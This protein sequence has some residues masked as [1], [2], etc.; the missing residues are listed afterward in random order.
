[1]K[2]IIFLF[3]LMDLMAYSACSQ[4]I[5]Q[6]RGPDRNG[7]YPETGLMKSW[8][9]TGPALLWHYDELGDGHSSAAVT[10]DRIYTCGEVNGIGYL[11]SF[12]LNGKLLWK[13]PYG[14]EWTESW[15]GVRST[16]LVC[17]G[18]IYMMSGFGKLIC[19]K[20]ESGDFIW[21]IDILKDFKAPNIKW[22]VTENLLIDGNKLFCTP[23]GP[24]ASVVALDRKTGKLLWKCAA[25]G[26]SSAYCSPA[27]FTHNKRRILATHTA[28]SIIGIDTETG[29]FL[30]SVDQP[31]TYSVHANTPEYIDGSIYCVSGYGKGGVLLKLSGDGS[32]VTETWRSPS[33]SNRMGG[34]V[35]LNGKIYGSDDAGKAWY[36][37]DWKTGTDMF[38]EKVT[39]KGN[40][41][42]ADGMLYLYGDNGEIVLAKPSPTGFGKVS[43][44]KVP[45]GSAQHWA[46][47]VIK[48]GRLYVRHGNSLMVYNIAK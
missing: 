25:K 23:G 11:Y 16:P 48:N 35:V 33:I 22:G 26:E 43:S 28:S 2:R 18:K 5:S 41:I 46:H 34:F 45:F 14:E 6:W 36:C 3:C 19:R 47:L 38:S 7:I 31:N 9:E 27:I 12:D 39:G 30:W 10:N 37:T 42:S 13:M 4:D 21:T 24:E 32:S 20:A 8:P 44:F 15:P 40:I 17:D 1:M 29:K